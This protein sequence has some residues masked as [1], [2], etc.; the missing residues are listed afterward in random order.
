MSEK[1]PSPQTKKRGRK[2][3][4]DI[5]MNAAHRKRISRSRQAA[6]GSV[7]FVVRLS[8]GTLNYIDQLASSIDVT[9]SK[10]IEEL[11]DYAIHRLA[12]GTTEAELVIADGGS[13]EAVADAFRTALEMP[14]KQNSISKHKEVLG[15][16]N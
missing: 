13:E 8:G 11:V 3:I 9:R 1:V 5:A 2:P 10:V 6:E 14:L 12:R 15:I 4:G 16:N 7:E